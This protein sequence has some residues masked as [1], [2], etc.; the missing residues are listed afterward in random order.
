MT[1]QRRP[2]SRAVAVAALAA[3]LTLGGCA[4]VNAGSAAERSFTEAFASDPAVASLDLRSSN[5]LPWIGATSGTVVARDDLDETELQELTDR[6]GRFLAEH[7]SNTGAFGI[8]AGAF[9]FPV[10]G[11]QAANE[12][13]L[14]IVSELQGDGRL[15][16]ADLST[17]EFE[18]SDA[19]HAFAVAE[20]VPELSERL[21]LERDLPFSVS[22][23]AG[24][25]QLAGVPG[26]W[27]A[28]AEAVREAVAPQVGVSRITAGPE[29]IE[30]R[31]PDELFVPEATELAEAALEGSGIDLTVSSDQLRLDDGSDGTDARNLL[32][33]LDDGTIARIASTEVSGS[34]IRMTVRSRED[35]VPLGK[36]LDAAPESAA[37][38]TIELRL[39][40]EDG[41]FGRSAGSIDVFAEPGSLADRAAAGAA[42]AGTDGI[43]SVS[44]ARQRL[45]ISAAEGVAG[46][47][48]ARF[49]AVLK[50][51]ALP[52]DWVCIFSGSADTLCVTADGTLAER[53]QSYDDHPSWS[54]FVRAWNTAS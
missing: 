21:G 46:D 49:A 37:F 41:G 43:A 38:S 15:V 16:R 14:G 50:R 8:E 6:V 36:A 17:L 48:F 26:E 51:S 4:S 39:A 42:L 53:D 28:E 2:A 22:T 44:M 45:E 31:V 5:D 25:V 10:A 7:A 32:G 12:R 1:S 33:R 27:V 23:S 35:L 11:D 24:D 40:G 9:S 3:A 13:T 20:E 34:V 18:V 30:L 52:G 29:S 54:A 19:E 47:D